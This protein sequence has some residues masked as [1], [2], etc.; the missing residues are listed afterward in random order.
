MKQS[1]RPAARLRSAGEA[2]A[3][4]R[5]R[6][7][8]LGAALAC[9]AAGCLAGCATYRGE[10]ASF[11]GAWKAGKTEQAASIAS[12][13]AQA[14]RY[15]KDELVWRLEAGAAH[16]AADSVGASEDQFAA[17][18]KLVREARQRPEISISGEAVGALTN[19]AQTRYPV[20]DHDRIQ[21]HAYQALNALAQGQFAV[22]R[23]ELN[24]VA[25]AQQ[26]ALDRRDAR[27]PKL[28][29]GDPA[30]AERNAERALASPALQN[31]LDQHYADLGQAR[32]YGN[33]VNP[34]AMLL[35]GLFFYARGI[36]ASE[37]ER[38]RQAFEQVAAAVPGNPYLRDNLAAIRRRF[39][40]QPPAAAVHVFYESGRAPTRE[41]LRIDLPTYLVSED[42]PYF[43]VALPQLR[44]HPERAGALRAYDGGGARIGEAAPLADFDRIVEAEFEDRFPAVLRR[45][46]VS[47][48]AKAL[49]QYG[50]QKGLDGNADLQAIAR[51][52]GIATQYAL[53][54]A[55][56]RSWSS[57][58][59][60]VDYMRLDAPEDGHLRFKLDASGETVDAY[61]PS[62][63]PSLVYLKS[64]NRETFFLVQVSAFSAPTV[65]PQP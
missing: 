19:P 36:G 61:V 59:K 15:T 22:A 49:A 48:S 34:L 21:L 47:A 31:A 25:Q 33:V 17:A 16:R 18:E 39:E 7:R 51:I 2:R 4:P 58:P 44:F 50:V 30:P 65:L 40:G 5:R 55:D 24:R 1:P 26:D 11:Y 20:Y 43:G 60:R 14:N 41:T 42:V 28:S 57:L 6:N 12:S 56:L 46:L 63:R 53:N 45:S 23:V 35:D 10:S 38:A 3:A 54:Q 13:K 32:A 37:L 27:A 29:A 62:D 8:R 64:L 52:A 9:V